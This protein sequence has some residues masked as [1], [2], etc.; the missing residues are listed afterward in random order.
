[1]VKFFFFF[2]HFSIQREGARKRRRLMINDLLCKYLSAA[3]KRSVVNQSDDGKRRESGDWMDYF[4]RTI[5]TNFSQHTS[6]MMDDERPSARHR[7]KYEIIKWRLVEAG[8][9]KSFSHWLI[10][11]ITARSSE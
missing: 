4:G 6:A 5:Q 8:G 3:P 9:G 11:Q 2:F 1:M 7:W 10:D